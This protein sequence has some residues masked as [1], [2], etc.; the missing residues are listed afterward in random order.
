LI[1]M[2]KATAQ[3]NSRQPQKRFKCPQC[4]KIFQN[5]QG[6]SGHLRYLHF[7]PKRPASVPEPAAKQQAKVSAP[8][9]VS[10]T[11]AHEHLKAAFAVLK[12][13]DGEIDQAITRLEALTAE[14]ETVR[15]ELA[16]V[17]AALNV[18]GER[19][20]AGDEG[21]ETEP[22]K[23]DTALDTQEAEDA[24]AGWTPEFTGNKTEFVRVVVQSRGPVGAEPKDIAQ[25]FAERS[26]EKSKNAIYNAL[27]SLVTQKKLKK[28]DGRYF[29]LESPSRI[30]AAVRQ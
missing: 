20:V 22:P 24:K 11:G 6:L 3:K 15:R 9:P 26:I 29:Y 16:A 10:S 25:V 19:G 5:A 1:L 14:R 13:R 17:T 28:K 12:Q 27:V 18:F 30:T 7:K 4:G 21:V 23:V 2:K 8:A